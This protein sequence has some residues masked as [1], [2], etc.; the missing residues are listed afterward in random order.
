M[1]SVKARDYMR[2]KLVTFTPETDYFNAIETL[3]KFKISSAPVLDEAGRVV[4]QITDAN[5][6]HNIMAGSYHD[7]VGGRVKDYM[8]TDF[9]SISPDVDVVDVAEILVELGRAALPVV[10]DGMLVGQLSCSDVLKAV[11]E[12][13]VHAPET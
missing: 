2:G 6:L 5:C 10:E 4:G 12:F 9:K 7:E 13:D 8:N 11:Y 1:R 3:L